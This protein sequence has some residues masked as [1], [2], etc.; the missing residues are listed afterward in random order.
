MKRQNEKLSKDGVDRKSKEADKQTDRQICPNNGINSDHFVESS[1]LS[2]RFFSLLKIS[3]VYFW[4]LQ[5]LV[6]TTK[7]EK[8][9]AY[10]AR[11]IVGQQ[12]QGSK[13]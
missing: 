10:A 2:V 13:F 4:P 9:A 8:T 1:F 6:I 12:I 5:P 3:S 11:F 7:K